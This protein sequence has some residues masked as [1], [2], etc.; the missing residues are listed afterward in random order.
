MYEETEA[1][2][3]VVQ[4]GGTTPTEKDFV[5]GEN[6]T[7]RGWK[8]L[9]NAF[10]TKHGKLMLEALRKSGNKPVP[11]REIPTLKSAH[12][13]GF[14]GASA[15]N[16]YYFKLV[17]VHKGRPFKENEFRLLPISKVD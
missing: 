15:T 1:P 17:L 9:E 8:I 13:G 16:G 2:I 11:V 4:G 12:L 6:P 14:N 3:R 5:D 10:K 7:E